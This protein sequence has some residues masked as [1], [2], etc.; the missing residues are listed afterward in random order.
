[1]H[2]TRQ[3]SFLLADTWWFG[4]TNRISLSDFNS[5][6]KF[7][8]SQGFN[9]VQI[10]AGVPP[11]VPFFAEEAKNEAGHPFTPNFNLNL[12]Y[13]D[14]FDKK[15][16]LILENGMTPIIYG[17][18]G[19]H[20]DIIGVEATKSFWKELM[21][22]Y[23]ALPVIFCLT[24]EADVFL[25]GLPNKYSLQ[26]KSRSLQALER[27]A[28][29]LYRKL[30]AFKHSIANSKL[31]D[32][33]GLLRK[34]INNWNEIG[35][36]VESLN[37]HKIPLTIHISG[38]YD[39][40]SLFENPSWLTINSIQ[41]GHTH[42]RLYFM[43]DKI[44]NGKKPIINLEPWYEGILDDFKELSQRQAFWVCV[45]SG[46]MGHGYGAHGVWQIEKNDGFMNH[47]GESN[48]KKALHFEGADALGCGKKLIESMRFVN[49]KVDKKCIMPQMDETNQ[50]FPIA[51][52]MGAKTLIYF[53]NVT[54][55]KF[56]LKLEGKSKLTW[57]HTQKCNVIASEFTNDKSVTIFPDKYGKED[58]LL[59]VE[60]N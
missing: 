8:K 45:L 36:Y 51:S 20:I 4:G 1:M 40:S 29:F 58:K 28:P 54:T 11:E 48:Y 60:R 31:S 39:A 3:N 14:E 17:G 35:R 24:G 10:V 6:L 56:I 25:N 37:S 27:V 44:L 52:H 46:A 47:W 23:G 33:N 2:T 15:I 38:N 32:Q 22:R 18:W 57:I 53:P 19:H 41:S 9:A 7:R 59:L 34:R 55:R 30:R 13:F 42:N 26:A 21:N 49:V 12:K 43:R 16:Q 5:A 50:N